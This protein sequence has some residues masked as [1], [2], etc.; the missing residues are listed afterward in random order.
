MDLQKNFVKSKLL[1]FIKT[2]SCC[3]STGPSKLIIF[4][5]RD[6]TPV[7]KNDPL[8]APLQINIKLYVRPSVVIIYK[9]LFYAVSGFAHL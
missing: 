6:I 2:N 1:A 4:V 8:G 7:Q 9:S 5:L 3:F